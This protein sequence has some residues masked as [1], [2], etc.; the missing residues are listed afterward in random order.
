MGGEGLSR[1]ARKLKVRLEMEELLKRR[2]LTFYPGCIA[3]SIYPGVTYSSIK[4]LEKLGFK[5]LSPEH[6]VCCGL[7]LEIAGMIGREELKMLTSYNM[8]RLIKHDVVVTPCNGCY[9][10]FNVALKKSPSENI[11]CLHVAEVLWLLR[12]KI[13]EM[14]QDSLKGLNVVTHVGCHYAYAMHAKAIKGVDGED[15]LEDIALSLGANVL[16]YEEKAT[17]CGAT[18]MK[19]PWVL[20][21]LSPVSRLKVT[22]MVDA[23]ADL[24]LVMCTACQLMID[25]TQY[26]MRDL[27]E[28]DKVIPV[29]HVSQLV[30]LALGFHPVED[31][32]LHLHLVP[33][34]DLSATSIKGLFKEA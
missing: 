32:G 14:A 15:L 11:E 8:R 4:V 23:D 1:G 28:L 5:V 30:G 2:S 7:P 9:R 17:C 33:P 31:V 18:A 21:A 25:K 6:V 19:W 24:I 29:L 3:T 34:K 12:E 16:S 26:Q 22:S 20:E 10:T 27:G 13:S